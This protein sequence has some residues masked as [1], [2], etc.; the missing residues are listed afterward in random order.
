MSALD[1]RIT[2]VETSIIEAERTRKQSHDILITLKNQYEDAKLQSDLLI[3]KSKL[4]AEVIIKETEKKIAILS[5]KSEEIFNE[6]KA[7]AEK[8]MLDNLKGEILVTILSMIETESINN[9][10][11]QLQRL[12]TSKKLL[13]KIWN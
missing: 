4:E 8:T 12:E 10:S 9:Q 11:E 3:N 6:Y 5:E 13:K 1:K 7:Q 2:L